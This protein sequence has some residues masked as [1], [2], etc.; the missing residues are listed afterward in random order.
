M[1]C[2]SSRLVK[3]LTVNIINVPS[4]LVADRRYEITCESSGSRPTA[5]ITWYKGKRQ[6][7]R[8]RVSTNFS[9]AKNKSKLIFVH[10]RMTGRV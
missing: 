5:I 3:P 8:T 9:K 7:R 4:S 10:E 1:S 2:Y 6:L